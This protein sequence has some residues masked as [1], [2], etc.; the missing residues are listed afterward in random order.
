MQFETGPSV[1]VLNLGWNLRRKADDRQLIRRA[2]NGK[3]ISCRGPR[4]EGRSWRNTRHC[5]RTRHPGKLQAMT[6][7]GIAIDHLPWD[8]RSIVARTRR[9]RSIKSPFRRSAAPSSR[10]CGRHQP[11][12][13]PSTAFRRAARARSR[14]ESNG[15]SGEFSAFT[16]RG[17][18]VQPSTT[19]SQPSS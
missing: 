2:R 3:E 16:I 10:R 15:G 6:L 19:A 5:E 4:W 17:I 12:L 11:G 9:L 7:H 18:S 14:V 1:I 8:Q 13:Y